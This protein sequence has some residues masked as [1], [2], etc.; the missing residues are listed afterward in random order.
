MGVLFLA[1]VVLCLSIAGLFWLCIVAPFR[2]LTERSRQQANQLNRSLALRN[3]DYWEVRKE[4][5][6][7]KRELI[8]KQKE[9]DIL[10]MKLTST[11]LE[12][13]KRLGS[14]EMGLLKT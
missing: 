9:I 4:L 13:A 14:H 8:M 6:A 10:K 5:D 2:S 11:Q 3:D 7:A 12:L 1:M